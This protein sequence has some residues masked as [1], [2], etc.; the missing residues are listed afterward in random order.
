VA[1]QYRQVMEVTQPY[2]ENEESLKNLYVRSQTG[3][4]V[5]LS[6]LTSISRG[7]L[8]TSINHQGQFP[9]VTLSFNSRARRSR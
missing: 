3:G 6:A 8:P 4:L 2:L 7:N 1:N 9:S 5:P